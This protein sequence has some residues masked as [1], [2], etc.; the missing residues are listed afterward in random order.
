MKA[1]LLIIACEYPVVLQALRGCW[2]VGL[3]TASLPK[4]GGVKLHRNILQFPTDPRHP[5][6][7]IPAGIPTEPMA[8]LYILW[9][10]IVAQAP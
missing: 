7:G 10:A 4:E 1:F 6:V 3:C 9:V 8:A 2:A 5:E